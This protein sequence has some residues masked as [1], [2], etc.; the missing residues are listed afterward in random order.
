MFAMRAAMAVLIAGGSAFGAAA[1]P[2]SDFDDAAFWNPEVV[3]PTGNPTRVSETPSATF[4]ITG[5]EIR[6]SGAQSLPEVLRRV[7]GLDVRMMGAADG[8]VGARG[9]G[10]ELARHVLV[11]VDGRTAQVDFFGGNAWE[12]LPISSLDIDRI[13]VV[14]GPGA[15]VYGNM[16]MLGTI[17]VIT[18]S[19]ADYPR[20]EAEGTFGI[21]GDTRLAARH[22]L[23]E[24]PWRMRATAAF[25]Q[26]SPFEDADR[27]FDHRTTSATLNVGYS[28]SP[29]TE[30]GLEGGFTHGHTHLNAVA[31]Q[32]DPF[33][34]TLAY[35]R[36][37]GRLGLGGIGAPLGEVSVLA[38]WSGGWVESEAFSSPGIDF[39]AVFH[40]AY[41]EAAHSVRYALFDLPMLLRWG[42]EARLNTLRSTITRD[43]LDILN[44]AAFASN[45][46]VLDKLRLT[47]GVRID[48]HTLT[49]TIASPRLSA[50]YAPTRR[51]QIRAA[52]N[53]GYKN[54]SMLVSFAEFE[55][56]PGLWTMG[57]R[58]LE[59]ERIRYAEVGYSNVVT[60]RLRLVAS[61]FGYRLDAL[62][63]RNIIDGNELTYTNNPPLFGYGGEAGAYLTL[64][65][66]SAYLTYSHVRLVG[67]DAFPY[68][69]D[70]I[71]SPRH[72][73]GIG[74][75]YET[76]WGAYLTLDGQYFGES[77]V[78]RHPLVD[79]DNLDRAPLSLKPFVM[80]HGRTGYRWANGI[81][82]SLTASNLLGATDLPPIVDSSDDGIHQF[83]GA[84]R[85]DRRILLTLA[86]YP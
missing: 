21:A 85:P 10:W 43:E 5:D 15:A 42:G 2:G 33:H 69:A 64:S 65:P 11:M 48:R 30:L 54:P 38:V 53:G 75:S 29:T 81:D 14:L 70:N 40:T 76:P 58:A 37:D 41:L 16:A 57:N 50:V 35:G 24:G 62:T 9:F 68:G 60:D 4:V 23:A 39:G 7:P 73:V 56:L 47:G 83:P 44:L 25:R 1:A 8:Q 55:A 72:K 86:Y 59:A 34:A 32:L 46:L 51:Q 17:N 78:D 79:G 63:A 13:E 20:L 52:L 19:A 77:E 3:T 66:L 82:L 31:M 80:V 71:G 26:L 28:P 45:E 22:G 49:R 18:R 74:G 6:R 61:L 67:S 27:S 12:M 84:V 36:A